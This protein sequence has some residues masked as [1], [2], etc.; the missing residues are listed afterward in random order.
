MGTN[1]I[2]FILACYGTTNIVVHSKILESFRLFI[3][4]KSIFLGELLDCMM[5]TGFW[6]GMFYSIC[7]SFDIFSQYNYYISITLSTLIFAT[8]SSGTSWFLDSINEFLLSF[9]KTIDK[10]KNGYYIKQGIY[11]E[12]EII[13][14][15]SDSME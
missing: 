7:F 11:T 9:V 4:N 6:V 12:E 2:L 1:I 14:M 13:E 15:I 5:C 8:I 10:T 3:S